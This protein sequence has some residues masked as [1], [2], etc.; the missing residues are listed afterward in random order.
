MK[1]DIVTILLSAAI[2]GVLVYGYVKIPAENYALAYEKARLFM[3][4][5]LYAWQ[6]DCDSRCAKVIGEEKMAKIDEADC[7]EL[8]GMMLFL[9]SDGDIGKAIRDKIV[10]MPDCD[11]SGA[12]PFGF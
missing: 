4:G 8:L 12:N 2:V 10:S 6:E 3:T 1:F 9:S 7:S 11:L 5:E